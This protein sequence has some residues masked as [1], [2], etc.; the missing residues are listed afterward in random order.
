[1]DEEDMK[2]IQTE[3]SICLSNHISD[4][5]WLLGWWIADKFKVLGVRWATMAVA[6]N[7]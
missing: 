2:L 7:V 6:L 3:S 4:I 5:D 1:M